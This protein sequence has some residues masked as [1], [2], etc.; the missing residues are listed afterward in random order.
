MPELPV[1]QLAERKHALNTGFPPG[2]A[3]R[4]R[5]ERTPIVTQASALDGVLEF[6]LEVSGVVVASAFWAQRVAL[7]VCELRMVA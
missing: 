3:A 6:G 1:I 2:P 7:S 4:L 5:E